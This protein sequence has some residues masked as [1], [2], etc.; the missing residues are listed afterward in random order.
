MNC[1]EFSR[2]KRVY[3]VTPTLQA[4]PGDNGL[5][6]MPLSFTV[7]KTCLTSATSCFILVVQE[8]VV[9]LANRVCTLWVKRVELVAKITPLLLNSRSNV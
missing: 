8:W 4:L 6:L 7:V 3:L 5:R 9:S 2:E 1:R